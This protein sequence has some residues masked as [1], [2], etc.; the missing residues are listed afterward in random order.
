M[1][2]P[3][4]ADRFESGDIVTGVSR[5]HVWTPDSMFRFAFHRFKVAEERAAEFEVEAKR[6]ID[7]VREREPG[8]VLYTFCRRS[9]EGSSLIP[10]PQNGQVEYMHLMAYADEAAQKL[11]LEIEHNPDAEWAWGRVFRSFLVAPL[12]NESF[13]AEALIT[14]VTRDADW[15]T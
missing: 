7:V 5:D 12:E 13:G 14:G 10:K 9:A 11:H 6:Q 4:Y 1:A 2:A 15:G 8:T 3:I